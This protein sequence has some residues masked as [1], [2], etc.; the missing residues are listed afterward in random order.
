MGSVDS[1]GGRG[2]RALP[3]VPEASDEGGSE[4]LNERVGLG[5][6]W[7][8]ADPPVDTPYTPQEE[9]LWAVTSTEPSSGVD[10]SRSIEMVKSVSN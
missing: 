9:D 8:L 7:D 4:G 2:A 3:P 10:F 5:S 1:L 6:R